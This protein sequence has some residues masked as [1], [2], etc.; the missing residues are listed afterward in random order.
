MT[1]MTL[2]GVM[3]KTDLAI[4]GQQESFGEYLQRLGAGYVLK[5]R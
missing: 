4:K 3:S 2:N 5:R 1:L